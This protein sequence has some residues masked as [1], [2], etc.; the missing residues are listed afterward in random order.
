MAIN[1]LLSFRSDD[2]NNVVGKTNS[3]N[4]CTFES[5]NSN[6]EFKKTNSRPETKEFSKDDEEALSILQKTM[7]E[8]SETRFN[9]LSYKKKVTGQKKAL[10]K[11]EQVLNFAKQFLGYSGE[12]GSADIFFKYTPYPDAK[13]GP[14]EW[15]AA[16]VSYVVE[17]SGIEVP[18]WF[19][20]IENKGLCND[21]YTAAKEADAIVDKEDVRPGDIILFDKYSEESHW[22]DHIGIVTAVDEDGTIHTIEG[23]ADSGK[24]ENSSDDPGT[25]LEK[26]YEPGWENNPDH[27]NTTFTFVRLS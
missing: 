22:Q 20:S 6:V 11:G 4:N 18:E 3:A 12:D 5:N 2:N 24:Y 15:C 21:I 14:T 13:A 7:D 23:N 1:R 27:N 10:T 16:F 19:E 9:P 25:V 26:E 8:A 17:E